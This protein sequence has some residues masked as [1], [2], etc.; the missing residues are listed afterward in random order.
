MTVNNKID[1]NLTGLSIAEEDSIG[2][3]SGDEI[4]QVFEP[5]SYSDFGGNLTNVARNPINSSRQRKK[6]VITDLDASGGFQTDLT[7]TN[8]Q[9]ILQGFFFADLIPKGEAKNAIG[10]TTN[11]ISVTASTDTFTR[12]GGSLDYSAIFTVGDLVLISGFDDSANNGLFKLSAVTATTV[13]VTSADGTDSAVVTVDEAANSSGSIVQVG[14]ESDAGDVDVDMTGSRPA[15]TSTSLDF[16]TLGLSIG[17]FIFIGGDE[18][19]TSFQVN[20]E[21]NGFAR[22]RSIAAIRL[23]FDKTQSTMV[24]EANTT[25]LI[26]LFF[27]RL[28]KNQTAVSPAMYVSVHGS[29]AK[30]TSDKLAT[31]PNTNHSFLVRIIPASLAK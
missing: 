4:W 15:L 10:V 20:S 22:I 9:D 24:T 28:L 5:N 8:M 19:E 7:Q 31:R 26:Q 23:E 30:A 21:N 13:V 27:G 17:E 2:V 1:A 3:V 11:T 18:D 6:G 14:V 29:A 25:E 12:I 16:T